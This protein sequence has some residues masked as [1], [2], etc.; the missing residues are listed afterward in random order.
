MNATDLPVEL[1][2]KIFKSLCT[3]DLSVLS[4]VSAHIRQIAS[5]R[6]YRRVRIES[7]ITAELFFRTLEDPSSS[8]I[9]YIFALTVNFGSKDLDAYMAL[10]LGEALQKLNNLKSLVAIFK[11]GTIAPLIFGGSTGSGM[12]MR[13]FKFKLE[14]LDV[15]FE[16]D[17]SLVAFLASQP[18]LTGLGLTFQKSSK[19]GL[20]PS[21]AGKLT[22]PAHILPKLR[23]FRARSP[24]FP[25]AADFFRARPIER[26]DLV[27]RFP[28]PDDFT[29]VFTMT[30]T[31]IKNVFLILFRLPGSHNQ[32]ALLLLLEALNRD[33]PGLEELW[34]GFDM[35]SNYQ[36]SMFFGSIPIRKC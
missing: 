35:K 30:C 24:N 10:S 19:R 29:K 27:V 12:I 36:V 4:L 1:F 11:S 6:L 33:L 8:F 15:S 18:T 32:D 13:E 20:G 14:R 16:C 28:V 2:D 3:S 25:L 22:V 26:V 34:L 21:N 17:A 5:R 31:P 23:G 7:T 9:P